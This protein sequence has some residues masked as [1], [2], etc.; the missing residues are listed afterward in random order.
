M[1]TAGF[2][3]IFIDGLFRL[4][5]HMRKFGLQIVW[6][7]RK[8]HLEASLEIQFRKGTEKYILIPYS[9]RGSEGSEFWIN[10]SEPELTTPWTAEGI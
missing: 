5:R 2:E 3:S 1:L 8:S 9:H 7:V 6:D 4:P 10:K